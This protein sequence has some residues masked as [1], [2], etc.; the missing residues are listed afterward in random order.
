[1]QVTFCNIGNIPYGEALDLQYRLVEAR[2]E[3]RI[4]D[5]VLL[6]E[7]PPVLT[8][9]T[10]TDAQNI[11][12]SEKELDAIGIG[13]YEVNRGG[14]VTYHGP[15]QIVVYP[16]IQ[17]KAYEQGIRWFIQTMEDSLIDLLKE[18]FLI[19]AY[20]RQDKY[21]GVWVEDRKIAAF[22]LAV[23]HGVTMH[24]FAFNVNTDLRHFNF[25]NPCGLSLGVTSVAN[26]LG[27]EID[28]PRTFDLVA[29]SLAAHFDWEPEWLSID[30]LKSRIAM[31]GEQ[32][33][34]TI[35]LRL[36]GG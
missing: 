25:I 19:H 27:C 4:G 14:D 36:G 28:L 20:S 18:E 22:G 6:L 11:Y 26:E 23:Q 10:R 9:G 17:L 35:G 12:L 33:T 32:Q 29:Q 31:T 5:T 8:K 15:G 16:I 21:T 13:V 7:H 24:G 30:Q 2:Q 1:M 34:Q 3:N